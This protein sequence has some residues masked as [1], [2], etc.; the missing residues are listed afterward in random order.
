MRAPLVVV[1]A[2]VCAGCVV[3][4]NGAELSRL[5]G[6]LS[7]D[8]ASACVI[9]SGTAGGG[10]LTLTPMPSVPVMGYQALLGFAR[11]NEPGSRVTLTSGGCT[12]EHG[13]NQS[14]VVVM[15]PSSINVTAPK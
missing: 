3:P 12:I 1:L 8:H 11:S 7:A 2:L 15:P 9:A 4:I 5:V 13:M 6:N 10:V 14:P